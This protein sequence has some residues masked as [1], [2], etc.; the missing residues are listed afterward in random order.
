MLK[1]TAIAACIA[2]VFALALSYASP[3]YA[4]NPGLCDLTDGACD[5]IKIPEIC[6]TFPDGTVGCSPEDEIPVT[7]VKKAD[8]Y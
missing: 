7:G 6:I 3:T 5:V 8:P 2:A 1:R 4:Y